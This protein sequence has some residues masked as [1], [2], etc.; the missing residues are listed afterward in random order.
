MSERDHQDRWKRAQAAEAEY[1]A[2]TSRNVYQSL[3]ELTEHYQQAAARVVEMLAGKSGLEA[4]EIGVGPM[5]IGFLQVYATANCSRIVGV[6]PLAIAPLDMEDRALVEYLRTLR[7]RAEIL[8][9]PAENL[10]MAPAS[11]D[12]ACC[13]NV[14]D[15]T[16]Q[17]Q[18][19]MAELARVVRPGGLLVLAVHTRSLLGLCKWQIDRRRHPEEL[20]YRAHPH[21]FLW[22]QAN[23]RLQQ[24]WQVQ[25]CD[26]PRL[27]ARVLG[28]QVMSTWILKRR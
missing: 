22:R 6:E 10:P 8:R 25:W 2:G 13:I 12:L 11:F 21:T 5:G 1:W 23:A 7:T 19:V 17:P 20:F 24:E 27:R 14:L 26:R 15:H 16:D 4:I 18:A 3:H 9:I 28:H